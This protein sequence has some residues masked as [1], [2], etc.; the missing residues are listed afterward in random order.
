VFKAEDGK[1][2]A[3]WKKTRKPDAAR[4]LEAIAQEGREVVAKARGVV[5]RTLLP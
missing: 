5:K 2:A 4:I 1:E 3:T